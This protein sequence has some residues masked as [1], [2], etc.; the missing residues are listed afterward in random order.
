MGLQ[1][2][3]HQRLI[4]RIRTSGAQRELLG[5]VTRKGTLRRTPRR[6]AIVCCCHHRRKA[7]ADDD[8]C[9]G[10]AAELARG[11]RRRC[12]QGAA[13][14]A[15]QVKVE[16]APLR[17]SRVAQRDTDAPSLDA[18]EVFQ[19]LPR[20]NIFAA[21]DEGRGHRRRLR[22]PP[23]RTH[24]GRR[25]SAVDPGLGAC[26]IPARQRARHIGMRGSGGWRPRWRPFW[27]PHWR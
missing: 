15:Q 26:P 25:A 8:R 17:E 5:S 19:G 10:A 4:I 11:V 13:R 12:D 7:S 23:E 6:Q 9:R 18:S 3:V 24:A 22:R 21:H 27:R 14:L 1:A 20:V 16:A 2:R